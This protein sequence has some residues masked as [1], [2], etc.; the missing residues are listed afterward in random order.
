M[1]SNNGRVWTNERPRN[2]PYRVFV[3]RDTLPNGKYKVVITPYTKKRGKTTMGKRASLSFTKK[4]SV[5][6][7]APSVPTNPPSASTSCGAFPAPSGQTVSVSTINQ[8]R[9]A[10][11]SASTGTTIV[12]QDGT[13]TLTSGLWLR[14]S[15]VTL[16]SASGNPQ[17]VVLDQQYNTGFSAINVQASDVTL[18]EFTIKRSW[19]HGV[20]VSPNGDHVLNTRIYRVHFVDN[21]QQ[22]LKINSDGTDSYY[23]DDGTVSCSRFIL[24]ASGRGNVRNNCYTG[25]VDGHQAQNWKIRNNHFEGFWCPSG[26]SEHAVHMWQESAGT[27]VESNFIKNCARGIGFG[28]GESRDPA[29]SY[30]GLCTSSGVTGYVGHWEGVIRNNII[31]ADDSKLFQSGSGFDCGIC[32]EQNCGSSVVHNTIWSSQAPFRSVDLRFQNTNGSVSNNVASHS[33]A[34]RQDANPTTST[35]SANV[36]SG[37]F[38]CP[39]NGDLHL[40]SAAPGTVLGSGVCDTDYEGDDRATYTRGAYETTLAPGC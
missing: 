11:S 28:L 19:Y 7:N 16:R 20:H 27:V 5:P 6:T 24:S 14:T 12:L 32:L 38:K 29:R 34:S 26:L 3:D 25:G 31:V 18:A 9:D 39:A 2:K 33:I 40:T 15:S 30:S 13:Y 36:G 1:K 8:L 21:A 4:C 22:Q 23:C 10:I 37:V 35:N 17:A